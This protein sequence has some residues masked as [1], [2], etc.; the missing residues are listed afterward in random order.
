MF[1]SDG[2]L[3]ASMALLDDAADE[4][5]TMKWKEDENDEDDEEDLVQAIAFATLG[6]N[7]SKPHLMVRWLGISGSPHGD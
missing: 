7:G 3:D 1:A 2:V 6:K 5:E 4:D